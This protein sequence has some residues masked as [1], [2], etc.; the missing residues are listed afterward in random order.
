[1]KICYLCMYIHQTLQQFLQDGCICYVEGC[2]VAYSISESDLIRRAVAYV[3]LHVIDTCYTQ[4]Q[5]HTL[6]DGFLYILLKVLSSRRR[7]EI[8]AGLIASFVHS[9]EGSI[10]LM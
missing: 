7:I 4:N 2:L 9:V 8:S 3:C 10:S 6:I 1:M 5:T